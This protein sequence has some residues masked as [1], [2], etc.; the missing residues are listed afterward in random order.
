MANVADIRK[1]MI[2]FLVLVLFVFSIVYYWNSRPNENFQEFVLDDDNVGKEDDFESTIDYSDQTPQATINLSQNLYN[3][4]EVI[5][6]DDALSDLKAFQGRWLNSKIYG[7]EL[8]IKWRDLPFGGHIYHSGKNDVERGG[9]CKNDT[10]CQSGRQ[11]RESGA[12]WVGKRCLTHAECSWASQYD[13][14]KSGQP[15]GDCAAN[16]LKPSGAVKNNNSD[17]TVSFWMYLHE[18][19]HHWQ[20]IFRVI[21]PHHS[22]RTPG[23][24]LWCCGHSALHIRQRTPRHWNRPKYNW[25]Q[26][27]KTCGIPIAEV[28]HYTI[29]FQSNNYSLYRNGEHRITKE[30]PERAIGLRNFDNVFI[31]LGYAHYTNYVMR[32]IEILDATLESRDVAAHYSAAKNKL[33]SIEGATDEARKALGIDTFST[34]KSVQ[35]GV[36]SIMKWWDRPSYARY[37]TFQTSGSL[38]G[39][40]DFYNQSLLRYH[41]DGKTMDGKPMYDDANRT[42][43]ME[44]YI[45]DGKKIYFYKFHR[46]SR[47]HINLYNPDAPLQFGDKGISFATWFKSD[48]SNN[49]WH[50]IFDFGNGPH[51]NNVVC[52]FGWG[53]MRLYVFNAYHA[54]Y[55]VHT[56]RDLTDEWYHMVWVLEPPYSTSSVH[57]LGKWKFYLNGKLY[58]TFDNKLYPATNQLSKDDVQ[59]KTTKNEGGVFKDIISYKKGWEKYI[60]DHD[61][62]KRVSWLTQKFE[63]ANHHWTVHGRWENRKTPK[64][65]PYEYKNM[66]IGRSN[67]GHDPFYKGY[68]GDF[69]IINKA[70]TADEAKEIYDNPIQPTM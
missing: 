10:D 1:H 64:T 63:H 25:N 14:K 31:Q 12:S 3:K 44:P 50:R 70:V 67:W 65:V 47:N 57:W 69:R 55:D 36:T 13:H 38:E 33:G 21:D 22:E 49:H 19:Q 62:L 52:A 68:I 42:Y 46:N 35:E 41:E 39:I 34:M 6:K 20:P 30:W 4:R 2:L 16:P 60:D 54:T 45:K 29:V 61:D 27:I 58:K 37:E 59:I 15:I 48:K 28:A 8:R 7:R 5:A 43:E 23:V 53:T 66:Y 18:T 9:S 17:F 26:E 51:Y 24:W 11:C 56:I 40:V 32:D